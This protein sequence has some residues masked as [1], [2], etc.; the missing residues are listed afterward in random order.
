MC[1]EGQTPW[2]TGNCGS[3]FSLAQF[4]AGSW[5]KVDMEAVSYLWRPEE[6]KD[7]KPLEEKKFFIPSWKWPSS[8]GNTINM[9]LASR[10]NTNPAVWRL[11]S[12]KDTSHFLVGFGKYDLVFTKANCKTNG[13]LCLFQNCK[14]KKVTYWKTWNTS[15]R[16]FVNKNFL[17]SVVITPFRLSVLFLWCLLFESKSRR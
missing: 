13:S 12:R 11:Y 17:F 14:P 16:K 2:E 15:S 7:T 9:D 4:Q 8:F 6:K 1:R 10:A 5:E 3:L